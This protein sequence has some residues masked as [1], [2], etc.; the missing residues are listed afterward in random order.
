MILG[1][2][3]AVQ[4][5]QELSY[6][7]CLQICRQCTALLAQGKLAR[8]FPQAAMQASKSSSCNGMY[9]LSYLHHHLLWVHNK[10]LQFLSKHPKDTRITL[11]KH[12]VN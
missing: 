10:S 7:D 1:M 5:W 2:E 6:L 12:S 8:M 4:V 11:K 9:L 3:T